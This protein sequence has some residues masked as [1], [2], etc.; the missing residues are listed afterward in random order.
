MSTSWYFSE[1][2]RLFFMAFPLLRPPSLSKRQA[3]SS[4]V[5]PAVTTPPVPAESGGSGSAKGQS[6]SGLNMVSKFT[7]PKKFMLKHSSQ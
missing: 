3:V 6:A 1:V 2:L 7:K 4:I 5:S